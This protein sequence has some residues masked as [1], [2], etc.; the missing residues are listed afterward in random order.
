[1]SIRKGNTLI[2]GNAA[3]GYR[4]PLLQSFWSDHILNR[5][6]LSRA[7]TFSWQSGEMYK[8]VYKALVSEYDNENSV[9]Q[10]EATAISWVQPT[11]TSLTQYGTISGT[12]GN[13][14]NVFD[15]STTTYALSQTEGQYIKWEF[16]EYISVNSVVMKGNWVSGAAAGTDI[17]VYTEING[18][19]ILLSTGTGKSN[20]SSPYYS[21]ATLSGNIVNNLIFKFETY[22]TSTP[23]RIEQ[24]D[25]NA[26]KTIVFKR[27]PKGYKIADKSQEQAILDKY[28]THGIAWIYILDKDNIQFKLPRT[29]FGFEGVRDSVGSDIQAGLPNITG[30]MGTSSGTN[31]AEKGL[32]NATDDG[33]GAISTNRQNKKAF[34]TYS[35]STSSF[36]IG[37]NFDASRSSSIYKEGATVQESATQM[38]LYFYVGNYTQSA[39]EETAGLNA[40]LFN[41]K[42]DKTEIDGEW[43]IQDYTPII[44]NVNLNSSTDLELDLTEFLPKDNNIYECI[45][46]G[47]TTTGK[48]SGNY[49]YISLR[50]SP[51]TNAWFLVCRGQTRTSSALT[52]HGSCVIPIGRQRKIYLNR[53]TSMNGTAGFL[54]LN[55]YRKVR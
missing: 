44:E 17:L 10:Y 5:P 52:T 30:S 9:E 25:I 15:K 19:E 29:K 51:Y 37:I 34:Q 12:I 26:N 18:E 48:T 4:P 2:A 24:I 21:T 36:V 50:P 54:N 45:I 3:F 6:D 38:Y 32:L 11:I 55:A 40:E 28:N 27:T 1:M 53:T 42:A 8:A 13:I 23:P 33:K 16:P 41:N 20:S 47:A 43:V 49:A 7:D 22:S 39:I 46:S 31:Q 14:I 35:S